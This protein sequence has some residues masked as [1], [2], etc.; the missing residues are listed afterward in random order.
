MNRVL[1]LEDSPTYTILIKSTI[2]ELEIDFII[3]TFDDPIIFLKS[4]ETQDND[5]IIL[6]IDLPK[7]NGFEVIGKI[8][9]LSSNSKIIIFSGINRVK[10]PYNQS[11]IA[12]EFILK[13]DLIGLKRSV[14]NYLNIKFNNIVKQ[15]LSKVEMELLKAICDDMNENEICERLC[16]SESSFHKRKAKLADKLGVKNRL[17]SIFRYALEFGLY[18]IKKRHLFYSVAFL[19]MEN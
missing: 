3:E 17:V 16:I 2:L 11:S 9:Q 12:V 18:E 5:I 1:I 13:P 14:C 7:I 8:S 15:D 4:Y 19:N 6:D 10:F